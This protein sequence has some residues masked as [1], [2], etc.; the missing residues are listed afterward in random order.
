[1]ASDFGCP[2][3][4]H[5]VDGLVTFGQCE[6]GPCS[7][8]TSYCQSNLAYGYPLSAAAYF[9]KVSLNTMRS[10]IALYIT[11]CVTHHPPI[12]ASMFHGIVQCPSAIAVDFSAAFQY[13]NIGLM[14]MT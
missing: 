5:G 11:I 7:C 14:P 4:G 8:Q 9:V 6:S 12:V 3:S 2:F 10:V 1:M 13:Q